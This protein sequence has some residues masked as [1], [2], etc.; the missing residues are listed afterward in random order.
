MPKE[1][2]KN[3]GVIVGREWSWPPAFI[4]EVNRRDEGVHAEFAVLGG[5][6]MNEPCPYD[7]LIDR[8]SHEI[9]YYRTYL[10]NAALQ[11]TVVVNNPF[12]WAADDK[13]FGAS[14]ADKLGIAHPRTIA[15]PSHSYIDGIVPTESLRNLQYPIP[16]EDHLEYVGGFPVI[17]KPAWGG[18]FKNVYKVNNM[19]ELWSAYNQTGTECM[20][21]QQYIDWDKYCR[22]LVLGKTKILVM[23]FD[24]NAPWPHRYFVDHDFLTPE[25]G[26]LVVDGALKLCEALGYDMNTVEFAIKDGVPYAIDFTNP[27]P[28]MDV[29]SLTQHYFDWAVNSMADL[30]IG[31]AKGRDTAPTTVYRWDALLNG[32]DNALASTQPTMAADVEGLP[33]SVEAEIEGTTA[34]KTSS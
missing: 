22:C 18:G 13:F 3:I 14:L 4:D 19:E 15:L 21:L 12:W 2:V 9:P 25:E 1:G 17:L 8:I 5:T 24:A 31:L 34:R 10:K 7:V 28:D 32:S 30:C 16:W 23:K 6:K 27:A 29:N 26:K 20:M 33:P 11:G